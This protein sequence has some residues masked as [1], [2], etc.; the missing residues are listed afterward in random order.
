MGYLMGLVGLVFFLLA[1]SAAMP[2]KTEKSNGEKVESGWPPDCKNVQDIL[3]HYKP[4]DMS[5]FEFLA[6]IGFFDEFEK[7]ERT[8]TWKRLR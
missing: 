7:I 8:K 1:R 2:S 3:D 5:N 6:E 4:E